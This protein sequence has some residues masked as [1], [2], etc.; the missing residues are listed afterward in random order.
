VY[1][2]KLHKWRED[3]VYVKTYLKNYIPWLFLK[4]HVYDLQ[5]TRLCVLKT[6]Y[7]T[8]KKNKMQ[9]NYNAIRNYIN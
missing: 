9:D 4:P 2:L 5:L 7:K 6:I 3:T 8:N 1:F